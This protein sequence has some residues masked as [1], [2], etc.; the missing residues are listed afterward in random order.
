[1]RKKRWISGLALLLVMIA[2]AEAAPSRQRRPIRLDVD[3][4]EVARRMIHARLVVPV[5]PGPL[6][7]LYPKWIP[8]EHGPT[9]PVTDLAGLKISAGNQAIRW[10]RDEVD[11][12]RI[13]CEVPAGI[14]TI[15]V[16][17]D[18]LGPPSAEAGFATSSASATPQLAVVTWNQLLVY[19]KGPPAAE[20][21]YQ[22]NLTLPKGWKLGTAL[23]VQSRSAEQTRFAP[24]SLET[25]IDSPVLCG[26]HFREVKI[27]PPDAPPHFIEMA[28]DSPQ[29]LDFPPPWKKSCDR[30][31]A[32][33]GAL[34]GAYHYD[35]YRFLLALSDHVA[36]FGLEHHKSSDNRVAESTLV[37]DK[38]RISSM[39]AYLLPHEFAHS[40]NGKHRRP[41]DMVT[42]DFN[43]PQRTKLLW[44]Y[45]GLTCYLHFLLTA[46]SGFWTQ[47]Q[48]RDYLAMIAESVR[49]QRGRIWR[50]LEDTAVAAQLLFNARGDWA[51]WRRSVD[52]YSEGLLIWLEVDTIIRQQTQGRRS[53][54]DFCRRFFGGG[55]GASAVKPYTLDELVATLNAVAPYDWRSLLTSRV[56]SIG[57]EAPL[58]GINRSGWQLTYAD[59]PPEIHQAFEAARKSIDLTAS[60]GLRMSQ[61]GSIIDVI[62]GKAADRAGIAPGTKLVAV[63]SRRWSPE[64]LRRAVAA[65]TDGKQPLKLLV[66]NGDFFTSHT[67]DYDGGAKYPRLERITSKADLLGQILKPLTPAPPESKTSD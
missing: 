23:P 24:V 50:P 37:D 46:R 64:L 19:P 7:L 8:G 41:Q 11:M 18:F 15:E 61:K 65:T 44:V 31:V 4:T 40:W 12:Y 34:F 51:A 60:V 57:P 54:D 26:R 2:G 30:L 63:N 35:G 14:K 55:N 3:A 16:A 58:G 27:G 6:T 9:G 38:L 28:A 49:N 39:G 5:A 59:K 62:P 13:H 25:L 47:E 36:H 42:R 67:L 29:A 22:V 53:F 10:H 21:E 66:E 1:M 48:A 45:E 32:E 52:F 33:A 56:T 20:I 17:L 43:Q